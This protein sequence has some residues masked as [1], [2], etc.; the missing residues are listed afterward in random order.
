MSLA[1]P[2][3]PYKKNGPRGRLPCQ[4][5]GEV[6]SPRVGKRA[7]AQHRVAGN[8]FFFPR[9]RF[10][11]PAQE[12]VCVQAVRNHR[13]RHT[14]GESVSGVKAPTLSL[15]AGFS[16]PAQIICRG[17]AC[18][19]HNTADAAPLR[20]AAW[21]RSTSPWNG[22]E[23]QSGDLPKPRPAVRALPAP[24]RAPCVS[25]GSGKRRIRPWP[26]GRDCRR[27]RPAGRSASLPRTWRSRRG[28]SR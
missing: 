14:A 19:E 16:M 7:D 4:L 11:G 1:G 10:R 28:H 2:S 15:P 27:S 13:P 24:V 22:E 17:G 6:S 3:A 23:K 18:L 25:R 12:G 21:R 5:G 26:A 8:T 9:T 20:L